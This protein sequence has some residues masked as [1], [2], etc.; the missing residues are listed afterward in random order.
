[1][2]NTGEQPSDSEVQQLLD[3]VEK[4]TLASHLLWGV[5]GIISVSSLC[6]F[7]AL[8]ILVLSFLIYL[9]KEYVHHISINKNQCLRGLFFI[10]PCF[11]TFQKNYISLL[12]II[13]VFLVHLQINHLVVSFFNY[14]ITQWSW[15]SCQHTLSLW[16]GGPRFDSHKIHSWGGTKSFKHN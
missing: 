3:E 7:L 1:M 15:L 6:P 9:M 14:I 12:F 13:V 11:S 8:V 5:W 16:V 2:L 4:Y 10:H